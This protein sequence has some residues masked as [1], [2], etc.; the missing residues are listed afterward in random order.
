[1]NASCFKYIRIIHIWFF[2]LLFV[3]S[4][5]TYSF[6]LVVFQVETV[7]FLEI[8]AYTAKTLFE[9]AWSNYSKR[10]LPVIGVVIAS[11]SNGRNDN[12]GWF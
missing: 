4:D 2:V 3:S 7:G 1:M 11:D 12:C 10:I 8:Y 6:I 5:R 9:K